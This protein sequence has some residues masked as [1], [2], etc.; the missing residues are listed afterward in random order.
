MGGDVSVVKPFQHAEMIIVDRQLLAALCRR[1]GLRRA[2]ARI[3]ET[4]ADISAEM[5]R[6]QSIYLCGGA[7]EMSVCA[8]ALSRH[9]AAIGLTTLARVTRDLALCAESGDGVAF[10]AVWARFE[11]TGARSVRMLWSAANRRI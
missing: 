10:A 6:M 2:E 8:Q 1:H 7:A 4:V 3:A 5:D 11:R 9:A